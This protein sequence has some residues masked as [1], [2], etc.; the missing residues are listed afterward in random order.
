M[1]ARILV[2]DDNLLNRK[3]ACDLLMLEGY[4]VLQCEDAAHVLE[5]LAQ[6][7]L[8][9]LILMDIS[10]PGMDGLTLTRQLK[11]DRRYAAIPVAAMTAFAM[12]GDEQKALD[13]GCSAYIT[14]P[15]DT[16]RLPAQVAELLS[17]GAGAGVHEPLKIMVVEDHRI[18]MKLVGASARLSGHVVL[19][20]TTAEAAL[21]SLSDG[22][23]DVVL[24]DLNLPGMDGLTFL[25]L[26]KADPHTRDL[27][28]V[29]V[30]AYPDDF[31]RGALMNAGC[32]AY[33]VKPISMQLLLRELEAASGARR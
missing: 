9:Q 14:K 30:T 32:S 18:D 8:P 17:A 28:V 15:I 16:R 4:D 3:L 19:S 7:R 11:A 6:E 23:P 22:H 33:L 24:L 27:P 25:R 2:V 31:Q 20:N 21:A 26:L 5:V 10:L 29:A 12:K 1:S 13:A